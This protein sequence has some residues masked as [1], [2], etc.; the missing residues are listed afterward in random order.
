M[1]LRGINPGHA[2]TLHFQLLWVG[3]ILPTIW[4][5]LEHS[6]SL[7]VEG[8]ALYIT[9]TIVDIAFYVNVLQIFAKYE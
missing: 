2:R 4:T 5:P 9:G 6:G 7:R 8:H 3:L 1:L